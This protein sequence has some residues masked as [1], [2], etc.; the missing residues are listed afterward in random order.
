MINSVLGIPEDKLNE[1]ECD[2]KLSSYERKLL[3]EL[4]SVLQP[5][6]H[7]T[8]LLQCDKDVSASMVLPSIIGLKMSSSSHSH[9]YCHKLAASLNESIQTRLGQ[10]ESDEAY[11]MAS[12]L[13]P[14]FKLRWCKENEIEKN[15]SLLHEKVAEIT[16][17]ETSE[18]EVCSPPEKRGKS[19][20]FF[21]F[22][23]S[24]PSR[25]RHK[26]NTACGTQVEKYLNEPCL[27]MDKNCL[28]FWKESETE[29]PHIAKLAQKYLSIPATSAPVERL[30][31]IAGKTFRPDR[32]RLTDDSFETLMTIR[33]NSNL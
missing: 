26:S 8:E 12:I 6:A 15:T 21:S 18:P 29:Y 10:Y 16:I 2:F 7:A 30:F 19:S 11:T 33:C 17:G 4:C 32:C 23:P 13:D 22:L 3:N 20:D 9:S 5:F 27:T 14:R 28:Q 25:R 24:T 31:S 1:I